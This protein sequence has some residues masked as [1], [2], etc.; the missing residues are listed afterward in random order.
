MKKT[1][2]VKKT[3]V[4]QAKRKPVQKKLKNPV[5]GGYDEKRGIL[6]RESEGALDEITPDHTLADWENRELGKKL[7]AQIGLRVEVECEEESFHYHVKPKNVKPEYLG[8]AVL[9]KQVGYGIKFRP[10]SVRLFED[11]HSAVDYANHM[12][13]TCDFEAIVRY[14]TYEDKEVVARLDKMRK[15]Q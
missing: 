14:A 3:K 9:I 1:K 12:A 5:V 11:R 7:S 8:Y 4:T 15:M 6:Y 13:E 2:T 10:D